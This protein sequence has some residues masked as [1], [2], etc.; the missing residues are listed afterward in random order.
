MK[1]EYMQLWEKIERLRIIE[2]MQLVYR[3]IVSWKINN[4]LTF[5]IYKYEICIKLQ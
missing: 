3:K 4:I 1:H 5:I 2:T